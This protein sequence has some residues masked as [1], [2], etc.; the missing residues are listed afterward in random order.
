[1]TVTI[2]VNA[3]SDDDVTQRLLQVPYLYRSVIVRIVTM[4]PFVSHEDM[5]KR[6][7]NG[8]SG[9]S[10]LSTKVAKQL[11]VGQQP[12][13]RKRDAEY[14]RELFGLTVHVPWSAWGPEYTDGSEEPGTIWSYEPRRGRFTVRFPPHAA[15][16]P[17]ALT[18]AELFGE[19]PC[20]ESESDVARLVQP[21]GGQV[22]T[23]QPAGRV[24]RN[25]DAVWDQ[26]E[27]AWF[28]ECG[29]RI[30]RAC[31]SGEPPCYRVCMRMPCSQFLALLADGECDQVDQIVSWQHFRTH[32]LD[33]SKALRLEQ[34]G[35]PELTDEDFQV[36]WRE[37]LQQRRALRQQ[38][39][40]AQE[41]K[42]R[43]RTPVEKA[44]RGRAE[45]RFLDRMPCR[46]RA[47]PPTPSLGLLETFT[48]NTAAPR[49][50]EWA[51]VRSDGVRGDLRQPTTE[52]YQKL[53]EG[54]VTC[55]T[56][57]EKNHPI[58]VFEQRDVC[59][60][61]GCERFRTTNPRQCCQDG[62]LLLSRTRRPLRTTLILVNGPVR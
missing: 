35:R 8:V 7:N 17:V 19:A 20:I 5:M 53:C 36:E 3:G 58:N 15:C 54:N 28:D 32:T 41:K 61:C 30:E 57:L 14:A 37:R 2:D 6:V 1:M 21:R 40:T 18:W 4:R 42:E 45:P 33:R 48:R 9:Q 49:G 31:Q 12:E 26:R 60:H 23:R 13:P 50:L 47:D 55:F 38:R 34:V 52:Q 39:L 51:Q 27:A 24:P 10:R 25:G 62:A 46:A 43:W 22:L 11:H 29:Q 59:T 44:A 16:Q 56:D